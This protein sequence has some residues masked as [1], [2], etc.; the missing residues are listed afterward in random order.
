ME[1]TQITRKKL[2]LFFKNENSTL[3]IFDTDKW[4]SFFA[5]TDL[6]YYPHARAAKSVKFFYNPVSAKFEPIGYDAHRSVPNYNK[7]I[8]SWYNLPIQNSFQDALNCKKNLKNCIEYGSRLTGNYLVY[9][10]FFDNYGNLNKEF[11]QKYKTAVLKV[12]STEFLDSF[13]SEREKQIEKII[14]LFMMTIFC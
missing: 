10:F 3:N 4:A 8:K 9:R 2:E 12:S 6:N 1:F 5:I 14:H 13:F 11:F 7:N